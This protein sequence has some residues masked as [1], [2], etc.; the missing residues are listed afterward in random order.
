MG[1]VIK[2]ARLDGIRPMPIGRL[3]SFLGYDM[4]AQVVGIEAEAVDTFAAM[5]APRPR[6]PQP[7]DNLARRLGRR[8]AIKTAKPKAEDAKMNRPDLSG[9]TPKSGPTPK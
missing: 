5:T 8:T 9:A 3:L 7:R 1:E 2:E 6:R 4:N